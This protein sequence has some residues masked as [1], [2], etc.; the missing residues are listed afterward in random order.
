MIIIAGLGFGNDVYKELINEFKSSYSVYAVT[1]AGFLGTP[2]PPMPD[3]SINYSELTWTNGIVEGIINLI[4]KENL[5]KPIIIAHFVTATQAAFNLALKYPD[6]IGKIVIIGGAPYRYYPGQKEDGSWSDWENEK[7]YSL[8]QRG[9]LVE[10][11]WAPKWFRT[12]TKKTWDENMWMPEDYCKNLSTGQLLYK[13]SAEVPL[14]VMIRYLIEWMTFDI[15]DQYSKISVPALVLLPDFDELLNVKNSI[16]EEFCENPSK[17]YLK[18]FHS[19]IAWKS[20]I[21]SDNILLKFQKVPNTRLFMWY[22]NPEGT[23][24]A[25]KRFLNF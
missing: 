25:I 12:V 15:S 11:Y 24:N 13:K 17:L 16:N 6:K 14:Q 23:Y 21:E 8:E 3:T 9:K 20:A 19:E 22:D 7:K 10:V 4:E 18:Y 2:A 5:K 1:P